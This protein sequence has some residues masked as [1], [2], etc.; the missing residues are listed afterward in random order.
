MPHEVLPDLDVRVKL[1][2]QEGERF[3][4]YG[5]ELVS[6]HTEMLEE[7]E[8]QLEGHCPQQ[9]LAISAPAFQDS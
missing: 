4:D 5:C 3:V 8:H 2:Q 1:N 7:L 6:V 9:P